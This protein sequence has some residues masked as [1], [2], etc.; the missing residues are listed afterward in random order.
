MLLLPWRRIRHRFVDDEDEIVETQMDPGRDLNPKAYLRLE[1]G[2]CCSF[3]ARCFWSC[4][5]VVRSAVGL[6]LTHSRV[7]ACRL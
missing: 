4:Q 7:G 1:I 2:P 3:L 6:V 5:G